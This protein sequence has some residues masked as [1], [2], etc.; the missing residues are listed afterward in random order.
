[1]TWVLWQVNSKYP[2]VLRCTKPLFVTW[3]ATSTIILSKLSCTSDKKNPRH[4]YPLPNPN[5]ES[6]PHLT[7]ILTPID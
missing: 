1:M 5:H 4:N 6:I 2:Q 3:W 7:L